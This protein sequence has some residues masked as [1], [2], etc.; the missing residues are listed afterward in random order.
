MWW[1][2]FSDYFPYLWVTGVNHSSAPSA[3]SRFLSASFSRCSST[4]TV[5]VRACLP[6]VWGQC[7]PTRLSGT[8]RKPSPLVPFALRALWDGCCGVDLRSNIEHSSMDVHLSSKR[9]RASIGLLFAGIQTFSALE[10]FRTL[11][12]SNI[13]THYST[14]I[15]PVSFAQSF[16]LTC[17]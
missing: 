8:F 11:V 6:Q 14:Q 1:C 16:D 2:F 4:H 10:W 9:T 7:Q 17:A 12:F 13:I 15:G 3:L 5:S